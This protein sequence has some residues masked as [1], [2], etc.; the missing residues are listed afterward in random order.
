MANKI[1]FSI[2][3]LHIQ[4]VIECCEENSMSDSTLKNMKKKR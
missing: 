3:H 2:S 1:L 4:D